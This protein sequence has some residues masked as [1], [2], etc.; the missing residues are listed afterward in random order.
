MTVPFLRRIPE[1]TS[2]LDAVT[3]AQ[4]PTTDLIDNF[5]A[6]EVGGEDSPLAGLSDKLRKLESHL[7]IDTSGI[8]VRLPDSLDFIQQT[9][10]SAALEYVENIEHA[11][12]SV[13]TF[14][15]ETPLASAISE[16]SNLTET[17][18]A[19]IDDILAEFTSHINQLVD[20]LIDAETLD[21]L[22]SLL[23]TLEAYQ[24]GSPPPPEELL[25]FLT[26]L[27]V[28]LTPDVFA[29]PLA[30]IE[31]T[32]NA[33][34]PL[35]AE[36]LVATL[37]PVRQSLAEAHA[38]LNSAIDSLD[39]AD[40]TGY[41]RI[42]QRLSTLADTLDTMF[43][44]LEGL[45]QQIDSAA[46][47][48]PWN[49]IFPSYLTLLNNIQYE[50][51][52]TV[53]DIIDSMGD[54]LE[55]ALA[56]LEQITD[57]TQLAQQIEQL[58]QLLHDTVAHSPVSRI[59]QTIA[60][61]LEEIRQAIGN[62]PIEEIKSTVEDMLGKVQQSLDDLG[63]EQIVGQLET[64]FVEIDG[65]VT[66]NINS[67]FMQALTNEFQVAT[68][69][70]LSSI[71]DLITNLVAQLGSLLGQVEA[72][73]TDIDATLASHL[74]DLR[75]LISNLEQLS[76]TPVS[77]VVIQEIDEIKQRLASIDAN[78]LG[79]AEKTALRLALS[80]LQALDLETEIANALRSGFDQ[81][82]NGF[83]SLLADLDAVVV[84]LRDS[85]EF[86]NPEELLEPIV[87]VM[88][89][90]AKLADRINATVLL[91]P[92]NAL[93]EQLE[94][95]LNSLSPGSLLGPLQS[96]YES[97]MNAFQ[98]FDPAHWTAPLGTIFQ[99]IKELLA[100]INLNPVFDRLDELQKEVFNT[101]KQA[102]MD[103][104]AN[105]DLPEPL[106]TF[107]DGLQPLLD[108]ITDAAFGAP[109]TELKNLSEY[110]H[111]NID[112]MMLFQPLDAAHTQLVDVLGNISQEELTTTIN[113]I[114]ERIGQR[115][116]GLDPQSLLDTFYKAQQRLQELAPPLLLAESIELPNLKHR[117]ENK[118]ADAPPEHQAD[119]AAIAAQFDSVFSLLDPAAA[120]TQYQALMDAHYQSVIKF[121]QGLDSIDPAEAI[122]LYADLRAH[123]ERAL[124]PFLRSPESLNHSDILAA[125]D[126]MRPSLKAA[127]VEN[128][129][130]R[131]LDKLQ[132]FQDTIAPA[133]DDLL[134]S[135]REML[136][137]INPLALK[138]SINDIYT[139]I[140]D[141]LK[142]LAPDAIADLIRE[143]IYQPLIDPLGAIEPV[144]IKDRI[145]SSYQSAVQAITQ[146][147]RNF[148]DELISTIDE[149]FRSLRAGAQSI[150]DEITVTM[151]TGMETINS[152]ITRIE[153]FILVEL[154]ARL[155]QVIDNLG[156]S[157]DKE[158]DR[159]SNSFDEMLRAIPV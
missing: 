96:P 80:A 119:I 117:F 145:N 101:T 21:N 83:K 102:M 148:I 64:A 75:N 6:L 58:S 112:P 127:P 66:D 25:A 24:V 48:L 89:Q 126:A 142:L 19:V 82:E 120:D 10:P 50:G 104:L 154:L 9:L 143:N 59:Q 135:I 131:F 15:N 156:T 111:T 53:D 141:K 49:D 67:E 95:Q 17:V 97:M 87:S 110:I 78:S 61:F 137:P 8:T 125:F 39:P 129:I 69:D 51:L 3:G 28:G 72:L 134:Q 85:L 36:S 7:Q 128:L 159:V 133:L 63:I 150:V 46:V 147:V 23:A 27:I 132:E 88:D 44:T 52:I 57:G 77:D 14:L 152:I 56:P 73:I 65:F 68:T 158:L 22:R 1:L 116:Y 115:L 12:R 123:L 74:N 122:I 42:Q 124:P 41:S 91:K 62:V 5:S 11:Y 94:E 100:A 47:Q 26:D 40:A 84:Q 55:N 34:E 86:F 105:L 70:L 130:N 107:F 98:R 99:Q 45:F 31:D 106:A 76:F 37:D 81:A 16:G 60:A 54:V 13:Q 113:T 155:N 103:A 140:D 146:S 90:L 30:H 157:F 18:V 29:G 138:E 118:V 114:R 4:S 136:M 92:I 144:K 35:H 153:Q 149:L 108:Q 151:R 121:Q 93:L 139:A 2:L 38:I 20:N 109:D 33:I 79:E 71:Q 43:A 32:Y